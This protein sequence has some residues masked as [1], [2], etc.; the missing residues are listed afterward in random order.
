M[1]QPE[2]EFAFRISVDLTAGVQ[3]VGETGKGI[4]KVVPIT[5]GTFE[6]P[7]IKGQ[8]VAGG[9]DWQLLRA[10]SVVEIDARY[11]LQTDD[12]DLIT[13]TNTGLR[14]GPPEVMQRLAKGEEVDASEYY[15]RSIPLFETGNPKYAWL[16]NSVFI[17]TGTRKPKQVL[18]DVWRVV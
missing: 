13:I 9:Y 2:L 6:G 5:G 4:R 16:M 10:D 7:N 15:F 17:A 8:V 1:Q 3:E 11:L 18:I 14:H 12:D